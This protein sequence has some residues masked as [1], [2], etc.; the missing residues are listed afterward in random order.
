MFDSAIPPHPPRH[1]LAVALLA[2][3]SG[4]AAVEL[5]LLLPTMVMLVIGMVD[6]GALAYQQMQVTAAA[7]AGALW[8]LQNATSGG[9]VNLT[10][11]SAAVTGSTGLTVTADPAPTRF[12]A[13]V[14]GG[15]VTATTGSSCASG[16]TPRWYV[17]VN[18]QASVSP[19]IAWATITTPTT[20]KATA[21][22]RI[23]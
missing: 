18:A 17:Q 4:A 1:G 13:C 16:G 20:L 6:V 14:S 22:V 21:L 15:A 11:V 7:H 9:N 23:Q 10:S 2:D 3:R 8:A 12:T 19:I 5:A